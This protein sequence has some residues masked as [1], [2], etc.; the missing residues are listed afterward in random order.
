M[1]TRTLHGPN[2]NL[3]VVITEATAPAIGT[4]VCLHGG[5]NG[6]YRGNDGIFDDIRSYSPQLGYNV[7]QFD[8]FGA[9]S[10]DGQQADITLKSQLGDY[11]CVFAFTEATFP[12]KIFVVGESMGATIAALAWKAQVASYLL[13]W[14]AFDL[15]DTD[16]QPYLSEPWTSTVAKQGYLDDNGVVVGGEFLNEIAHYDFTSC[17]A[18]PPVPCLLVH[19]KRDSAVPFQQSLDAVKAA[20]GECVLFAHPNGD[21]GLQRPEERDFTRKA[22]QWWLSRWS[23]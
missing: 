18:L 15:R 14:P 5:P 10:S 8:M 11:E 19:G 7:V 3:N 20:T 17:F 12:G 4:L 6:D 1:T 23:K 2:G 21:H 16:L 9:G 22:I 13:L